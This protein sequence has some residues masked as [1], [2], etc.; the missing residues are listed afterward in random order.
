MKSAYLGL[1][2]TIFNWVFE[3]I[4]SPIIEFLA[5]LLSSVFEWI[6][7]N[8]LVPILTL[9]IETVTPWL[10]KFFK[11]LFAEL[12]YKILAYLCELVDFLEETFDIFAGTTPVKDVARDVSDS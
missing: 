10:V 11:D 6:F 3:K 9:V 12:F 7:E 5:G 4:L 2:S 1:F 8:I